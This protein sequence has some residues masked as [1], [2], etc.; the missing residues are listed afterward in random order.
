M[1]AL[2]IFSLLFLGAAFIAQCND[3]INR[4]LPMWCVELH[5]TSEGSTLNSTKAAM[6]ACVESTSCIGFKKNSENGYQRL[7][8]LTGYE[9]N[10]PSKD[11]YL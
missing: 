5:A 3:G 10:E 11:Y 7:Y 9:F 6:Q 1:G 2:N 8:G 4:F